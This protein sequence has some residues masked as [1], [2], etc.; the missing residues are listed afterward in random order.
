[1]MAVIPKLMYRFNV[2]PIKIPVASLQTFLQKTMLKF[3]RNHKGP[4]I[5]KTVS[6]KR[7]EAGGLIPPEFKTFY[8]VIKTVGT[9][10]KKNI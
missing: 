4:Y 7:N 8:E 2:I 10:I 1:M 9:G 3:I 6:R 5:A